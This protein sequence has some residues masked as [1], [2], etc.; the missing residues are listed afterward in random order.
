VHEKDPPPLTGVGWERSVGRVAAGLVPED[1]GPVVVPT[2]GVGAEKVPEAVVGCGASRSGR[3]SSALIG[4][5]APE[6][7]PTVCT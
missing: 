5:M 6:R 2:E 3:A 4:L 7:G 1:R